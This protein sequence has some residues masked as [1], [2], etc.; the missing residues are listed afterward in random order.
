MLPRLT[1]LSTLIGVA[2]CGNLS[3]EDVLFKAALPDQSLQLA[4]PAEPGM[5]SQAL[6]DDWVLQTDLAQA[7]AGKLNIF[8]SQVLDHVGPVSAQTPS[9]RASGHREWPAVRIAKTGLFARLSMD[10]VSPIQCEVSSAPLAQTDP[11]YAWTV[12]VSANQTTGF[13]PT[14][15]GRSRGTELGHS[16][17]RVT[18]D[19]A[20]SRTL[21]I[22]YPDAS[23]VPVETVTET[24]ERSGTEAL[25]TVTVSTNGDATSYLDGSL[26][27]TF[28]QLPNN[29][30]LFRFAMH[31]D[32]RNAGTERF[33]GVLQWAPQAKPWRVD[34][35]VDSLTQRICGTA[36]GP[37]AHD[38]T[39][40][41]DTLGQTEGTGETC[42]SLLKLDPVAP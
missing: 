34:F 42:G 15:H 25:L 16:C 21:G 12:E 4:L 37:A 30:G 33:L 19:V 31:D 36:C 7:V 40:L 22:T 9:A 18:I 23:L 39:F 11:S 10:Q 35:C 6:G 14:I 29:T 41:A 20:A 32:V 8:V 26:T 13:V 24:W 2:A 5:S 3:N 28:H 17:G 27:Y 1:L 38:R